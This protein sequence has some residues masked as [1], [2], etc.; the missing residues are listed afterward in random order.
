MPAI[1]VIVPVYNEAESI[2]D[3]VSSIKS[4]LRGIKSEIIVVNDGSKD[5]TAKM[6]RSIQGIKVID[7]EINRGYGFSLKSAIRQ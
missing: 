3:T 1:S 7:N 6:L 5:N 2:K 4:A